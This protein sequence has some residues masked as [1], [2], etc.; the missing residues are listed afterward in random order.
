MIT[1]NG[2]KVRVQIDDWVAKAKGLTRQFAIEVVQD[3]NEAV[4]EATPI[5][6][7][8]LRGSWYAGINNP[9]K[10]GSD[11]SGGVGSLNMVASQINLGDVYYAVNGANYAWFVE[12]GTAAHVIEPKNKKVLH[13]VDNGADVFAGRVH[14]PGTKPRAFVRT[15]LTRAQEIGEA[16]ANR[17]AQR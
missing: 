3:I 7:G 15:T 9:P 11:G 2:D 8:F 16:A 14:H 13:W 4:V 10:G 1:V 12:Y 5:K 6:T 17:M